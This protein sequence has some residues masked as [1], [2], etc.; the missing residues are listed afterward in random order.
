MFGFKGVEVL[1]YLESSVSCTANVSP[2][3][4]NIKMANLQNCL[5]HVL[6]KKKIQ[7]WI[8]VTEEEFRFFFFIEIATTQCKKTVDHKVCIK[9]A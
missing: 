8:A 9:F 3:S 6:A 1:V 5:C 2:L 4:I 7:P